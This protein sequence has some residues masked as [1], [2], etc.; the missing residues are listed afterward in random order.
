MKAATVPPRPAAGD[1]ESGLRGLPAHAPA[2]PSCRTPERPSGRGQ[3]ADAALGFHVPHYART[4]HQGE[5]VDSAERRSPVGQM[6]SRRRRTRVTGTEIP[7]RGGE[8]L[9]PMIRPT[10]R[11]P[12]L[13]RGIADEKL[14]LEGSLRRMQSSAARGTRQRARPGCGWKSGKAGRACR[15][16]GRPAQRLSGVFLP[17]E[18]FIA[19]RSATGGAV[20]QVRAA[21]FPGG[22]GA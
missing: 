19:R 16:G 6:E 10:L 21:F 18:R 20:G 4:L 9:R 5:D 1:R 12:A 7:S 17:M 8:A 11:S 14:S 15:A 2:A 13:A 3:K 22:R